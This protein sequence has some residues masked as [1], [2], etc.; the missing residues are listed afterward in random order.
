MDPR[1]ERSIVYAREANRGQWKGFPQLEGIQKW[2]H[3]C[4]KNI[5]VSGAFRDDVLE[6]FSDFRV[7]LGVP[8]RPIFGHVF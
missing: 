7:A 8:G 1:T 3:N 5:F 4:I 6:D 2:T